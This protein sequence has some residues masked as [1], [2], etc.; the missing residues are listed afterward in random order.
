MIIMFVDVL[1]K[2]HKMLFIKMYDLEKEGK[3]I[4]IEYIQEMNKIV[5]LLY[6]MGKPF[7]Y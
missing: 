4:P 5:Q 1:Y 3:E 2:R 6:D 7:S